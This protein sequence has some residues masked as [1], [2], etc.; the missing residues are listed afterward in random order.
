MATVRTATDVT[1]KQ[2]VQLN[3]SYAIAKAQVRGR[4]CAS[5]VYRFH[6]TGYPVGNRDTVKRK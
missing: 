2:T 4:A 6:T 1:D 5:A 3:K